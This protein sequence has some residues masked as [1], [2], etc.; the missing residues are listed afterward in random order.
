MVENLPQV[1]DVLAGCSS[2]EA[3]EKRRKDLI[4]MFA[5]LAYGKR[6]DIPYEVS[7]SEEVKEEIPELAARHIRT[8]ITVKTDLGVHTFPLYAYIPEQVKATAILICSQSRNPSP[9][10]LP[11]GM[12]E[13]GEDIRQFMMRHFQEFQV[14]ITPEEIQEVLSA[15]GPVPL[16][17]DKD[18]DNEHWP[19]R[20]MMQEGLAMFG[21]YATDAE[22]DDAQNYPSKL[23]K[24]F[25]T[26][27]ERKENEWG[28]LSVWA[29]AASC[30]MDYVSAEFADLVKIGK[31]AVLGHSRCG[32]AALWCG[33]ND[34]RFTMTM[35]NGSGCCG[36]ALSRGK[37]G[38]NLAAINAVFPH[39][40]APAYRQF[41]T[42][43]ECLPFDQHELLACL[44]PRKLHVGSGSLDA[45][46]DP[47][48]EH[49]AT[50]LAGKVWE[51]YGNGGQIESE[52]PMEG[53][54]QANGAVS[55]HLRKGPHKLESF[56]WKC[57]MEEM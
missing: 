25:G 14:K 34:E 4:E 43:V 24:I 20:K 42:K 56:D 55:Y 36:A 23:G 44:A 28:L 37:T 31:F 49:Y 38:E 33:V 22:A 53:E 35:P 57:M 5:N 30:V 51:L 19:V 45:W 41:G 32:K 12:C 15:G 1:P 27:K 26:S 18:Y 10:L 48:G 21:F 50:Y 2:V 39:W 46:S 52:M 16:D 54:K 29:F 7:W 9:N 11:P 47:E 6:P 17:M 40:F 8:K 13:D 3:W